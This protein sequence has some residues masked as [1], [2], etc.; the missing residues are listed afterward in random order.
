MQ[1]HTTGQTKHNISLCPSI[2]SPLKGS[3]PPLTGE[4]IVHKSPPSLAQNLIHSTTPPMSLEQ[5]HGLILSTRKKN[6]SQYRAID[7]TNRLVSFNCIVKEAT[8]TKRKPWPTTLDYECEEQ[9]TFLNT[10]VAFRNMDERHESELG[11]VFWLASS[12]SCFSTITFG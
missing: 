3:L 10:I 8:I 12:K 11:I 6:W 2:L 4:Q 7:V 9:R 1:S 5:R